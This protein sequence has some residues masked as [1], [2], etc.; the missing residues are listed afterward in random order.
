M[1]VKRRRWSV[2][3]GPAVASTERDK[4]LGLEKTMAKRMR[5]DS[6]DIIITTPR[7][8]PPPPPAY[9]HLVAVSQPPGATAD[10]HVAYAPFPHEHAQ[11]RHGGR[12]TILSEDWG[13]IDMMLTSIQGMLEKTRQSMAVLKER[14]STTH[15]E[16]ERREHERE[17]II[18]QRVNEAADKIQ[19][20]ANEEK[21]RLLVDA[22]KQMRDAVSAAKNELENKF[23]QVQALAVQEALKDNNMQAASKEHCWNCGRRATE[24]CSGCNKARY[25]GT[26]CQHKDWA[27]H[28]H[29]CAS[30]VTEEVSREPKRIHHASLPV[31]EVSSRVPTN[32]GLPVVPAQ[33]HHRTIAIPVSMISPQEVNLRLAPMHQGHSELMIKAERT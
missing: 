26:F 10:N 16:M 7:A 20:Q 6:G 27:N 24:T 15:I 22:S 13:H 23:Q 32:R 5:T 21:Q 25:C 17:N 28:M 4:E 1:G 29:H 2:E 12:G 11:R 9:H 19:L 30:G 8:P 33:Q 31:G 14:V 18:Q 3:Q